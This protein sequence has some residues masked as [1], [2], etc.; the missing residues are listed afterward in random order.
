MRRD[1]PAGWG[2]A[3]SVAKQLQPMTSTGPRDRRR[4]ADHREETLPPKLP[5]LSEID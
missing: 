2:V 4:A 3:K 5:T 1:L